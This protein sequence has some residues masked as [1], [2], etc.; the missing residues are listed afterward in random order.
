M[1]QD[2]VIP[3][4]GWIAGGLE[5]AVVDVWAPEGIQVSIRPAIL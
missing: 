3:G 2:I 4:L 1:K 5:K